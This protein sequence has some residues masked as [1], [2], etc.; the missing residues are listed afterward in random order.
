MRILC[1]RKVW[2]HELWWLSTVSELLL[3]DGRLR[4]SEEEE[5]ALP[6]FQESL[7]FWASDVETVCPVSQFRAQ[8]LQGHQ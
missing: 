1:S 7:F 2:T 5:N 3:E 6:S 8:I 4:G